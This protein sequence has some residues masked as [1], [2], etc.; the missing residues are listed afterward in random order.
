MLIIPVIHSCLEQS[1]VNGEI[2][3]KL[4][5]VYNKFRMKRLILP[6]LLLVSFF[7]RA[8]QTFWLTD[9]QA[10]YKQA[11]EYYQKHDYS[12]AYP[13]FRELEQDQ[14][15]R[16]QVYESFGYENVHYYTLVCS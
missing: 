11:Q 13:I 2:I 7:A 6:F 8:Q 15:E 9:P 4:E 12:L 5:R 10:T 16:P 14:A 1:L 3:Q